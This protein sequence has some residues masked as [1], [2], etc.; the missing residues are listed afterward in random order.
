MARGFGAVGIPRFKEK[1]CNR[2]FEKRGLKVK[3]GVAL[4]LDLPLPVSVGIICIIG[5]LES[6]E[7][8]KTAFEWC[9]FL[10]PVWRYG[11]L[12]FALKIF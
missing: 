4:T 2:D 6:D 10:L 3:V 1:I 12:N 5:L 9:R 7:L 11:R 8:I